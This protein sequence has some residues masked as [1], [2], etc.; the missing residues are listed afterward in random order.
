[1]RVLDL[2]VAVSLVL[3]VAWPAVAF[4]ESDAGSFG[5]PPPIDPA[6]FGKRGSSVCAANVDSQLTQLIQSSDPAAFADSTGMTFIDGMVRVIIEMADGWTL[7]PD[8][9][10]QVEAEF[11]NYSQTLIAPAEICR[12]AAQA[13]V[14]SITP[15]IPPTQQ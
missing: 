13:G 5:P 3:A 10:I 1:M 15:A 9:S 6:R 7:P 8:P 12:I 4:A 14:Q 2:I 11:A